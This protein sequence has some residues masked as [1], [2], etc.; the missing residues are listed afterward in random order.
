MLSQAV[1]DK[2]L[3]YKHSKVALL[4]CLKESL[5]LT[6]PC[7]A[8]SSPHDPKQA[9]ALSLVGLRPI[10]LVDA[11][12]RVNLPWQGRSRRGRRRRTFVGPDH[13]AL[14]NATGAAKS[15]A[16]GIPVVSPSSPAE[17][18]RNLADAEK[19]HA[20]AAP[21]FDPQRAA[22]SGKFAK[23]P[24]RLNHGP[25]EQMR[26][27]KTS[28]PRQPMGSTVSDFRAKL[29]SARSPSSRRRFSCDQVGPLE[30]AW[31]QVEFPGPAL[32]SGRHTRP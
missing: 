17:I 30:Y 27:K 8:F 19:R 11:G 12:R 32:P 28:G 23:R 29:L 25:W 2:Y 21:A 14:P 18:V 5:R 31:L 24:D 22:M 9:L 26:N 16:D 6:G 20:A 15:A 4:S 10:P 7:T 1:N 13:R 3:I